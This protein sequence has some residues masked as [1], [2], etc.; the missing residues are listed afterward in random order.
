[1]SGLRKLL[2]ALPACFALASPA[3]GD[4]AGAS[5]YAGC[6]GCH[7]AKGEGVTAMNAPQLAGQQA[8]YLSR[9]LMHFRNGSRGANAEDSFGA[10]M[11]AMAATLP[12]DAAVSAVST[13]LSSLKPVANTAALTDAD[14]VQG[15]AQYKAK[16][17]ACHG[18]KAEGNA[19]LGAPMLSSLDSAYL[20]RQLQ[21]YQSG[22]RNTGDRYSKQMAMMARTLA[23]EAQLRDVVAFIVSQQPGN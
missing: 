18:L 10:Q 23:N 13:Y 21:H 1:M 16:C 6:A 12:D 11:R 3:Q 19:A 2:L 5:L 7:G 22:V 8:D 14:P 15:E 20:I 9:Q 17:N 4:D